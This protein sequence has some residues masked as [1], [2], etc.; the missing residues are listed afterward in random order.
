MNLSPVEFG[1]AGT[2]QVG[3]VSRSWN[4][5]STLGSGRPQT[6]LG[7]GGGYFEAKP[8]KSSKLIVSP[9]VKK[10]NGGDDSTESESE[11]DYGKESDDEPVQ[12]RGSRVF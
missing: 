12:V 7:L 9:G 4:G 1:G 5:H 2:N 6:P 3:G 11:G 10:V 8:G